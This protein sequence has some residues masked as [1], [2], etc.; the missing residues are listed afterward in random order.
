MN[1]VTYE[2]GGVYILDDGYNA[3]EKG[4]KAAIDALK[5]FAGRK[6][7]VTPG[8]VEAGMLETQIN[9]RLGALLADERLDRVILVGETLV[10]PVKNGFM[11]AGG[12]AEKLS[13]VPTLDKAQTL[14]ADELGA[15]DAVLFL[16]DLPDV[17]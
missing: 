13:V 9:E 4:A 2:S 17:Y 6:V 5:R 3:N 14:L 7:V 15:G 8:I 11:Q 10:L 1:F 12:L 16:N